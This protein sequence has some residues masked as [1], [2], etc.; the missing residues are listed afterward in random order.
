MGRNPTDRG[1]PGT[2]MSLIVEGAGRP[3]GV[4]ND[5][6]N[7]PDCKLLRATI[8]AIVVER[9][10]PTPDAPPSFVPGE[11]VRQPDGP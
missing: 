3:L 9:P 6:A 1:K 4:V 8:E 5:R 11:G 7:V 2:K 10:E